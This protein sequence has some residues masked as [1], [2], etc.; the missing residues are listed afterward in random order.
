[1]QVSNVPAPNVNG[2]SQLSHTVR[3]SYC[4]QIARNP[5]R[6]L[7]K[8]S[9]PN[10]TSTEFVFV[11]IVNGVGISDEVPISPQYFSSSISNQSQL[12]VL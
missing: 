5:G 4:D 8:L 3:I 10:L 11:M 6:P 7:S 12:H 2:K 1:M 9:D